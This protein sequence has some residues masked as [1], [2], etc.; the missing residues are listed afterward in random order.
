MQPALTSGNMRHGEW[1]VVAVVRPQ[2]GMKAWGE[3]PDDLGGAERTW[4]EARFGVILG[5][6]PRK[7]RYFVAVKPPYELLGPRK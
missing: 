3:L 6:L 4:K 5:T 2:N 7:Q 1:R